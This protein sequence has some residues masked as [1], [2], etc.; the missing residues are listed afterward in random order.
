MIIKDGTGKGYEAKVGS[1]NRLHTYAVTESEILEAAEHGNA[2]NLNTGWINGVA[3]D[4]ALMYFYNGEESNYIVEA[5]AIGSQSG[6]THSNNPYLILYSNPTGG[7][8]ISDASAAAMSANRNFG[9]SRT[10]AESKIYKGKNGGTVTGGNEV[11]YF[12]LSGGSRA[13]FSLNFVMPKGSSLGV[14]LIA[15]VSSG[16]AAYYAALIGYQH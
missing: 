6:I 1:D 14:K 5:I 2:Y 10:L 8:I 4:S 12:Q 16:S 9:S 13:F 11:G 15:N 3:S 7:D